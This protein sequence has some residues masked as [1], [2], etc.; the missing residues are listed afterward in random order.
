MNSATPPGP[1]SGLSVERAQLSLG[2]QPILRDVSLRVAR[3]EFVALLGPSGCGKTTLMRVVAGIQRADSGRVRIGGRD[4]TAAHPAERDVAMVFQSYALYPHLTVAQNIAVPLTMT[5]LNGLQRMPLLGGM[6]PG[7]RAAR[8]GIQAD[9]ARG[10]GPLGLSH[11][12]DRKPGQLSGG[13]RQRVALARAVIRA[14]GAFLM[15]EPLSNLDAALRVTTRREIVEVHRRVGAAT[16]YVTHDQSEALTMADRI[17]VMQAGEILQIATPEV[18]YRDPV[19]LR[20]ASFIGSPR[21]NLLAAMAGESG[22]VRVAGHP[23]PLR[24]FARGPVTLAIRPEDWV[25][26][27]EGLPARVEHAEFLGDHTLV[28]LRIAEAPVVLRTGT[29]LRVT[30][31]E[32]LR[33]GFA[34]ERALLFGADGRRIPAELREPA[35]A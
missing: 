14:P 2:G 35:R 20:V 9:V 5:R 11:L 10:A 4:V 16:L 13:Q 3:G 15:D 30:V 24:S 27:A 33:L 1:D 26:D 12:L 19:D 17:A 22:E 7:S 18:I 21:I 32:S 6:M 31:G 25:M 34:P 8:A 29:G 23:T 28:H